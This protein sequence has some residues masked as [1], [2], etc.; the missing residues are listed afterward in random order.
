[1]FH[2]CRIE[3]RK[4]IKMINLRMG[5]TLYLWNLGITK[6]MCTN[7]V[8]AAGLRTFSHSKPSI[9]GHTPTSGKN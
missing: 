1:V 5:G 9:R 7:V 2:A 8:V 3:I 6:T 4:K